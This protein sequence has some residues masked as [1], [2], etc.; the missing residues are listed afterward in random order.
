[1]DQHEPNVALQEEILTLLRRQNKTLAQL[2]R[3]IPI[4]E[5]EAEVARELKALVDAGRVGRAGIVDG[6]HVYYAAHGTPQPLEPKQIDRDTS[7]HRLTIAEQIRALKKTAAPGTVYSLADLHR[8]LARTDS[9]ISFTT[10]R[11]VVQK[12]VNDLEMTASGNTTN[13]R[14]QFANDGTASNATAAAAAEPPR[15]ETP[16]PATEDEVV[17]SDDIYMAADSVGRLCI[18][19]GPTKM[20]FTPKAAMRL[21]RFIAHLDFTLQ[22]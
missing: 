21:Q 12:L 2:F 3:K 7:A 13:R 14:Y 1:M 4:A 6:E 8:A 15:Q 11:H 10:V 5:D 18:T 20:H 9:T 17:A 22:D 16:A 19:S